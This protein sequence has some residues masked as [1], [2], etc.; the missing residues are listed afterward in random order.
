MIE[1]LSLTGGY[2]VLQTPEGIILKEEAIM[3]RIVI[4]SVILLIV[5]FFAA[6]SSTNNLSTETPSSS[7]IVGTSISKFT[8]YITFEEALLRSTDIVVAQY[9]GRRNFGENSIELEFVVM[10]RVIGNSADSIF[11]YATNTNSSTIGNNTSIS[12]NNL[13]LPFNVGG[14]YL[15]ALKR[16]WFPHSKI[17]EDGYILVRNLIVDLENPQNSMM[18]TEALYLHFEL[19]FNRGHLSGDQIIEYARELARNNLP[20]IEYIMSSD[21]AEVAGKSE[22]ILLVE[23]DELRSM[24]LTDFQHTDIFYC[25]VV[26]VIKGNIEPGFELAMVFLADTV[27]PGEQHIIA[28][29]RV[30]E[31]SSLFE[32]TSR[33][34]LFKTTQFDEVMATVEQQ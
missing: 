10:E 30:E 16:A 11:V 15:L 27:R 20:A 12:Y 26:Q 1:P 34:S 22:Y 6:C 21:V 25:T 14:Q 19:D 33:Y 24:A 23:V 2:D 18:Y 4:Y 31:G 29:R 32:F 17:H 28:V 3:K 13:D 7:D 9:V 8:E 5:T